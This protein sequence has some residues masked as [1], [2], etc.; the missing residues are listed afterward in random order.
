[1]IITVI[2]LCINQ[3]TFSLLSRIGQTCSLVSVKQEWVR[4]FCYS[5][6]K[7]TGLQQ[8]KFSIFGRHQTEFAWCQFSTKSSSYIFTH[9]VVSAHSCRTPEL[10]S[11]RH[12]RDNPRTIPTI[13]FSQIEQHGTEVKMNFLDNFRVVHREVSHHQNVCFNNSNN[14]NNENVI[15]TKKV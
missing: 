3:F 6:K 4:V 12:P 15:L 5:N 14:N 7:L 11:L 13:P 9:V 10:L 2:C 8:S 1:M